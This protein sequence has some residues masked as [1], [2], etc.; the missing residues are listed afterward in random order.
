MMN[1]TLHLPRRGLSPMALAFVVVAVGAVGIVLQALH[2]PTR[3][4]Y[5]FLAAYGFGVGTALGALILAM[6]LIA[7]GARWPL[8]LMPRI[9]AVSST[10]P[11]FALLFVPIGLGLRHLYPWAHD[12]SALDLPVQAA[13]AHQ[14]TWNNPTFFLARTLVYLASWCFLA[15]LL[16]RA[17]EAQARTPSA[18]LVARQRTLSAAGLPI[19]AF[20]MTFASFDWLMSVE[21]GWVSNAYGLYFSCGGLMSAVSLVAV[22]V[23][24]GAAPEPSSVAPNPAHYHAL[25]RLMLMAVILWAYIGFF[26]LMLPWIGDL[27][28]EVGFF[29]ARARGSY[30]VF[31]VL[32]VFGHFVV[33]FLLLLSRPLKRRGATLAAVG[34]WLVLMNA[35]DVAWLVLPSL[36]EHVHVLDLAPFLFVVGLTFAHALRSLDDFESRT[37]PA[38]ERARRDPAFAESARYTSP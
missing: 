34:A 37:L 22:S 11:V 3:A 4:L 5:A 28:R 2:D 15:L 13:I 18:R 14:R 7:S 38:I 9:L 20:T 27:P 16:S 25:G 31:D 12:T 33:P 35:V 17:H 19:V 26:Q 30:V 32:L 24:R 21:P 36:D 10:L 1:E 8:V 23:Y 29:A 6:S